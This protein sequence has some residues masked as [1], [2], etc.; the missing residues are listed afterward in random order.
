MPINENYWEQGFYLFRQND[1]AGRTIH[2][3]LWH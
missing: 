1:F 2:E 3:W